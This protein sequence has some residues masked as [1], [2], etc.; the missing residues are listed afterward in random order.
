VGLDNLDGVISI[1]KEMSSNAMATAALMKGIILCI[2]IMTQDKHRF[3]YLSL[4][5][6]GLFGYVMD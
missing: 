1:I 6:T 2:L 4:D 5:L 3:I